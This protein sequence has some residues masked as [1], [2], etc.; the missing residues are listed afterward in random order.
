MKTPDLTKF[1]K[2]SKNSD[3]AQKNDVFL[4]KKLDKMSSSQEISSNGDNWWKK[5][6]RSIASVGNWIGKNYESLAAILALLVFAI[7]IIL[8]VFLALKEIIHVGFNWGVALSLICIPLLIILRNIIFIIL[9]YVI[10]FFRFVFENIYTL[11]FWM[12]II[13]FIIVSVI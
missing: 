2:N 9:K 5:T 11:M 8:Y 6:N 12:A 10:V 7:A 13:I 3:L 4:Q 1:F